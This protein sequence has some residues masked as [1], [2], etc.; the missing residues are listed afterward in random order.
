M[1]REERVARMQELERWVEEQNNEFTD[2]PFPPD[3]QEQ[4]E[5]N[6][7]ELAEHQLV[8]KEL[9]ERDAKLRQLAERQ[10]T[11]EAGSD[12]G[13][14]PARGPQR[15]SAMTERE[16]Y[17]LSAMRVNPLDPESGTREMRD[18]AVRAVELAHFPHPEIDEERA[19]SHVLRLLRRAD[20]EEIELGPLARRILTTGNPAYKR[21]F[22]KMM[23]SLLRGMGGIANLSLEEQRAVDAVRAM[24]VGT[25]NLGG[26]AVPYTLDPTL[27]PSSNWSV[28]PFRAVCRTEQITGNEWRAV[29]TPGTTADYA[30]E[31]AES[32]DNSPTTLTQP[33]LLMNRAQC[34]VPVSIELTQDWGAIQSELAQVISDAKDDLE[35]SRF[36]TGSGTGMPMGLLTGATSSTNVATSGSFVIGDL[37]KLEE[38]VPPRFRPRSVVLGNRNVFNKIRQF[39]TSGGAGIWIQNL[40]MG[41]QNN[42]PTPG[43]TGWNVLGYPAYEDTAMAVQASGNK[44]LVMGDP[45]YYVV[46][47]RIG[48]DIEVIPHLFGVS[49]RPTGQRGFYAFWRNNATVL[50]A[51]AFRVLNG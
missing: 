21:A 38:A 49:N 16:V 28:N 27:I 39:D 43:T 3:I 18:R 31:A 15:I 20:E 2:E 30:S 6:N 47:D 29:T 14:A 23:G 9:E 45:R 32:S 44:L 50:H 1:T 40:Q 7:R 10:A 17:D 4:W 13:R 35:A 12:P 26:F 48:M 11:R 33:T 46:V 51:N 19:R 22:A 8:L 34:F 37:Y 36:T 24:A 42:P 25:G 41:I 5:N